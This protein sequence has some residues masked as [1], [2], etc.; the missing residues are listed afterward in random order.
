MGW[1]EDCVRRDVGRGRNV[2]GGEEGGGRGWK[3]D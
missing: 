3:E 1:G 2:G